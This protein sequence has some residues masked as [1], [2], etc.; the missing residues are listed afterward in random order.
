MLLSVP[1]E[2]FGPTN[3]SHG[4]H[5]CHMTDPKAAYR[6]PMV[7][8]REGGTQQDAA[9]NDSDMRLRPAEPGVAA[10]QRQ[11]AHFATSVS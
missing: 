11:T 9:L 7:T 1:G 6:Q 3:P 8:A 10:T 5:A 4:C 2:G